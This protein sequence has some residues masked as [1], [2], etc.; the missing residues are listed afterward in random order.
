MQPGCFYH[1]YNRGNNRQN[2]FF[3]ERNY[4]YFLRLF[5]KYLFNLVDVYAYCLMPNHFHF[6]IKIKDANQTSE[7]FKTSEVY[8]SLPFK[9]HSK[10]S[11]YPIQ[12]QSIKL[13]AGA[14]VYFRQNSNK[15]K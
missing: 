6:L 2:I 8:N 4:L 14:G 1:I 5:E 3:E 12:K 9:K 10:T 15:K 13:M 7:V 11:L